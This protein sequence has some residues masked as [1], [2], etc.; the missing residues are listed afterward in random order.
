MHEWIQKQNPWEV[1]AVAAILL[2]IASVL[3]IWR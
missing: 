3:W 1:C 2:I